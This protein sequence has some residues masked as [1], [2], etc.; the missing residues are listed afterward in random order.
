MSLKEHQMI[1]ACAAGYG[2]HAYVYVR[3]DDVLGKSWRNHC[4]SPMTGSLRINYDPLGSMN[5]PESLTAF[6]Y[7]DT[8]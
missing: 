3:T 7:V 8:A 6:P 1:D 4:C 2:P 5:A